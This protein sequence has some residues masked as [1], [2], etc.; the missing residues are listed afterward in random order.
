[1]P[2]G[3]S[4]THPARRTVELAETRG[5]ATD[6]ILRG[7][8]HDLIGAATWKT[9]RTEEA[10]SAE[11]SQKRLKDGVA[12]TTFP[13]SDPTAELA[14]KKFD[15]ANRA[16]KIG[17]YQAYLGESYVS[18]C[19]EAIAARIVSGGWTLK[20]VNPKAPN[21]KTREPLLE[22]LNWTNADES[23]TQVL[24]SSICDLLWAGEC[25]LEPTWKA[26]PDLGH[27]VPYELYTVD[28]I[29]MDYVLAD[30]KKSIKGYIQRTD[31]GEPIELEPD[32]VIRIW[33]P[34]PRNKLKALSPL[35]KLLNP[36]VTDQY[37][38]LYEIKRFEQGNRGDVWLDVEDG[39]QDTANRYV[40]W[41]REKFQGVKN[42]HLP[43]ITWGGAKAQTIG[44]QE[45][46]TIA[47]RKLARDEILA[48]YHVPPHQVSA[49]EHGGLGAGG[50][51]DSLD[52]QFI[53]TGCDPVKT[54]VLEPLNFRLTVLGFGIDD[55][56]IDTS[57][58]DLRDTAEVDKILDLQVRGGRRTVN[59]ARG[60][61]KLD[62]VEG[63]DTAIL[64][65]S[66]DVVPVATFPEL[67]AA[68]PPDQ[69]D[70]S[71]SSGDAPIGDDDDDGEGDDDGST[72]LSKANARK[73][74]HKAATP[75]K[76]APQP[77]KESAELAKWQRAAL[78][79]AR[80]GKPQRPWAAE[81]IDTDAASALNEAL[82]GAT[83][84]DQVR[85]AFTA[86]R[87]PP[88]W[89]AH[90]VAETRVELDAYSAGIAERMVRA[91]QARAHK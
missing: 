48:V 42:S 57:Y 6:K 86:H 67:A 72:A 62:P 28:C 59:E 16:R 34:D 51:S 82:A 25:F 46:D 76:N 7:D 8:A 52:K 84:V 36:L 33:L 18:A 47:R 45:L 19:I 30:D 38:Q 5:A 54:R 20:P 63:G 21:E 83:T 32:Q 27:A 37:L 1:M 87:G 26:H 60:E 53:H 29:S 50:L 71:D 17:L 66:K 35:E 75:V 13:S 14:I 68:A 85:E 41:F 11:V 55:W 58:A 78:K 73:G 79:R 90:H 77:A 24:H 91:L 89:L 80:E 40:K 44:R 56:L 74:A 64:V 81:A 43:L 23:F 88:A 49:V 10:L 22:F 31:Q 61:M 9:V 70:G 15:V 39:D 4:L 65:V 2:F 3:L 12:R 69:D